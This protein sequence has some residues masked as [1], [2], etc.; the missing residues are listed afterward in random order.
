MGNKSMDISWVSQLGV[1]NVWITWLWII[2][3]LKTMVNRWVISRV[4]HGKKIT[5]ECVV[6]WKICG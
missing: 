2:C 5:Q 6:S 4:I 3:G 1:D